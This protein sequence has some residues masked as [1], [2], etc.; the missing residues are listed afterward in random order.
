M[1]SI[2]LALADSYLFYKNT[3]VINNTIA[4]YRSVTREDIRE[5]ARQYLGAHQRLD[6]DYLPAT[7]E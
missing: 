7:E 2:A 5:A 3:H 6:L 4:M 1:E